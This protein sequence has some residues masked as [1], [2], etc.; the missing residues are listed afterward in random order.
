M[1]GRRT[2]KLASALAAGLLALALVACS[3]SSTN[4]QSD[5]KTGKDSAV[6]SKTTGEGTAPGEA[7]VD[8]TASPDTLSPDSVKSPSALQVVVNS[9]TLPKA[10]TEYA[11]DL[12]G[13]GKNDNQ[14]GAVLGA[15]AVVVPTG[16]D[17]QTGLD[18]QLSAGAFLLLYDVLAKSIV[19]D[20]GMKVIFYLGADEDGNASD[21]FS[22]SET[23]GLSPSNPSTPLSLSGAIT[24][25]SM[26]VT[27][28]LSIP[29]PM[30]TSSTTVTLKKAQLT[31]K[32]SSSGITS[33]QINGAIPQTE[34]DNKL[35][36]AMATMLHST[37]K[38]TTDTTLKNLLKT[39]DTDGDGT[40]DGSDL[41]SNLLVGIFIKADVDT[42][43]DKK[44]DSMSVGLAF[45]AVT[46]TID[47]TVIYSDAGT[48]TSD[49]SVP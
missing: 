3:D 26:K 21:N 31:G 5:S 15:L 14:L 45:T 44:A 33:G 42:D 34:M 17:F 11:V 13:N 43:G 49:A 10:A 47:K 39:F 2:Q 32:L 46:C 24:S 20:S 16:M 7:L 38:T 25:S 18:A 9:L 27:G 19:N 23:L 8:T 41:K 1:F 12:D 35:L 22:G 6:D 30:G 48:P 29:V 40:I 28:S 4:T 36:P 37:Y